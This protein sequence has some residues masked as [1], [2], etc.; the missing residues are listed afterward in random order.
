MD[1]WSRK[2]WD[3]MA[4]WEIEYSLSYTIHGSLTHAGPGKWIR[5]QVYPAIKHAVDMGIVDRKLAYRI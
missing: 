4:D 5:A 2:G 1:Y 3:G